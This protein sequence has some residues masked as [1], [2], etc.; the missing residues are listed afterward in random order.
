ERT[1]NL[2]V[3]MVLVV[4]PAM[5]DGV[6]EA[7][8]GAWVLGEVA[9]DDG[10]L[11]DDPFYVQGAKGVDG[12]AASLQS[13]RGRGITGADRQRTEGGHR[14]PRPQCC[15][16]SPGRLAPYALAR[17]SVLVV[18]VFVLVVI[19]DVVLIGVSGVIGIIVIR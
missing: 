9:A 5:A 16:Y 15:R 10:A 17:C 1:W 19:V 14:S 13:A 6:I 11:A 18:L 4:D 2:G 12:G 7:S 3:G 8:P